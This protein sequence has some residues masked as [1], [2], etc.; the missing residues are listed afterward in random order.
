[1]TTDERL[2]IVPE[3]PITIDEAPDLYPDQWVLMRVTEHSEQDAPV[4][5]VVLAAG[6]DEHVQAVLMDRIRS[7]CPD[8]PYFRF[9]AFKYKHLD[10]GWLDMYE[11][12]M[13]EGMLLDQ[14][15]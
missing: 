5:G 14:R 3:R 2:P 12:V 11:Q 7:G 1:M 13:I 6:S 10:P 4:A 9:F 8:G 15:G